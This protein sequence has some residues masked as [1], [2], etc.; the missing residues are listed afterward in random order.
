MH[1]EDLRNCSWYGFTSPRHFTGKIERGKHLVEGRG[2][3][4]RDAEGRWY[5]DARSSLWQVTLGYD[6]PLVVK[7]IK[8]QLDHLPA[9]TI[10]RYERPPA[11]IEHYA[12]ALIARLPSKLGRIRFGTTGSQMNE[13][14]V[15]LSRFVRNLEGATQRTAVIAFWGGYHGIGGLASAL[16]GEQ[17]IQSSCGPLAPDVHHVRH[18]PATDEGAQ[19][20]VAEVVR[21]KVAQLGA[22]R[23]TA[24]IVEPVLGTGAVPLAARDLIALQTFCNQA[25]I[26][27]IVDEVTTGFGRTGSLTRSGAIGLQPDMLVLS[28]GMTSGYVPLAALAV[29][30]ELFAKLA[31]LSADLPFPHG[32]TSDGNPLALAAGLGVLRALD[33]GTIYDNVG[34]AH[35]VLVN[36]LSALQATHPWIA[37]VTGAG[38][39]LGLELVHD[40]GKPWGIKSLEALRMNAERNGVLIT[41]T[42]DGAV[43]LAPPLIVTEAE[44]HQIVEALDGALVATAEARARVRVS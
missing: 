6:H 21:D 44:C 11:L 12:S 31:D 20:S 8:E 18:A 23:V 42:Y 16:T 28:K 26:H 33:D 27:L 10:I 19:P 5:L 41:T 4:V 37:G 25:G 14:A 15:M 29:S 3:R 38:L 39:L 1:V 30:E 24:V 7:E 34:A 40:E 17:F 2:A 22:E 32:S 13:A 9:G 35:E 43:L 36:E